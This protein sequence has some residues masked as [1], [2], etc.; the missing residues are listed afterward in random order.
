MVDF[1]RNELTFKVIRQLMVLGN[2]KKTIP[3]LEA[4]ATGWEMISSL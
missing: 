1:N 3:V 4:V 2:N